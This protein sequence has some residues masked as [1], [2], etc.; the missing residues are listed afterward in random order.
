[1][2]FR[3]TIKVS[4]YRILVKMWI[5]YCSRTKTDNKVRVDHLMEKYSVGKFLA[6]LDKYMQL[7]LKTISNLKENLEIKVNTD[8]IFNMGE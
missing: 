8:I 3:P 1:M 4:E 7:Q 6:D 2:T 5:K